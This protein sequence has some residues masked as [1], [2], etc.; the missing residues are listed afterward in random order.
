MDF[1]PI[2]ANFSNF[3]QLK[4]EAELSYSD[5]RLDDSEN[6]VAYLSNF[7]KTNI[8]IAV[9]TWVTGDGVIIDLSWLTPQYIK[10]FVHTHTFNNIS[11]MDFIHESM[12]QNGEIDKD[13]VLKLLQGGVNYLHYIVKNNPTDKHLIEYLLVNFQ[14]LIQRDTMDFVC[15]Y[16]HMKTAIWINDFIIQNKPQFALNNDDFECKLFSSKAAI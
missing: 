11:M 16:C 7:D 13:I 15:Q 3:K 12:K 9:F 6:R 4:N 1:S 5:E 8:D 10:N 2:F 14:I